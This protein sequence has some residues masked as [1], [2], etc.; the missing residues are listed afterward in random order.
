MKTSVLRYQVVMRKE[1]AYYIADVPTLGISDFGKT[2]ELAKKNTKKAIECHIE[3]LIKTHTE[4]PKPD[5]DD[6]YI[7]VTEVS[8]PRS[9][10][11]TGN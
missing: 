1:G 10:H 9:V 4:V 5:G 3:G 11:L 7:S 2:L 8:V 6:Y